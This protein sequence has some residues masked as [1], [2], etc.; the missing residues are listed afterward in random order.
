MGVC[1][2]SLY[3][4]Y[5]ILSL[6]LLVFV[7]HAKCD[8]IDLIAGYLPKS[9]MGEHL[10]LDLDQR[11][12]EDFLN[13]GNFSSASDI[14]VNGGNSM[15][16]TKIRIFDPLVKEFTK[17]AIVEQG[18][19]KGIL[20]A[21]GKPGAKTLKVGVTSKCIGKFSQAKDTSGCFKDD[22]GPLKIDGMEVGAQ[23]SVNLPYR[24]LAGFS[25]EAESKMKG[26]ELFEVYK[27]YYGAS[28]YADK[29]IKAALKGEDE[30]KRVRVPMDFLGKED[31]FRIECAKKGSAYWSVWMYVIREMEDAITDCKSGCEFCNDAPVHA[32]DEAWAFYTGSLEGESGRE[33]GRCLYRLAEKRCTNYRTCEGG[34]S[35]V[36]KEILKK[37]SDGKRKLDQG[38]CDEI[39]PIKKE[40]VNLMSI[41]L[42]QGTL[43]YA[44]KIA[45]GDGSPKEKA[46]GVAFLGAII[47]RLYACSHQD[48]DTV[49][50]HMWID[51][52][53][54]ASKDGFKTVK[55]AFQRNYDCLGV[56]CADIGGHLDDLTDDYSKD[57]RPCT[58]RF[59]ASGQSRMTPIW[60][61][62]IMVF[63]T[64]TYKM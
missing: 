52:D 4:M 20:V 28:D 44:H 57:F 38:K 47:P 3:A 39:Q 17:G 37:F 43:R 36:N 19:A 64:I 48:A 33:S 56:R 24:T 61:T 45:R 35:R 34:V 58:D 32:W 46:E 31:I 15:K 7:T 59:D 25:V 9:D 12:F 1:K 23:I 62:F 51:G 30:T 14:Y 50:Q 18:A 13:K 26:Q 54:N 8:S 5:S 21:D 53:M 2:M 41:P 29:F 40:I 60:I 10:K 16:S 27:A 49:K 11:D 55:D 6:Y 63:A 22:G 42:I